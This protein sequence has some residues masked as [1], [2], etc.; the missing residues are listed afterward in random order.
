V[1][2][3]C[4]AI[5]RTARSAY[6]AVGAAAGPLLT[7]LPSTDTLNAA[8]MLPFAGA[9]TT[10]VPWT[11]RSACGTGV[12]DGVGVGEGVGVGLGV[13]VGDGVGLGVGVG[14]GVGEGVGVGVAGVGQ[15]T[16][17]A[18]FPLNTASGD[19]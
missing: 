1:L 10:G 9:L 11:A 2:F 17:T 19:Q 7:M 15:A 8:P 5:T 6:R 13:G 12:G 18:I 3:E 14:D 16:P 4:C